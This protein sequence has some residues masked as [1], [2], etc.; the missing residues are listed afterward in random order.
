MTGAGWN[1]KTG[2][3]NTSINYQEAITHFFSK[4][5]IMKN[6]YKLLLFKSILEINKTEN[7]ILY[8]IVIKFAEL[9]FLYKKEYPIDITIYNG[10]SEKSTLDI[11]VEEIYYS[12]IY[13]YEKISD[14]NKFLYV[15]EAK[16]VLKRN[17]IGAFYTSLKKIPYSFDLSFEYIKLNIN[18]KTFLD[19]NK[20]KLEEIIE[21]RMIEFFKVSE[22]DEE[23]LEK[24]LKT[25][26]F[27]IGED[28]Y[29]KIND[30]ITNLKY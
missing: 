18:F 6:L 22:K 29:I 1:L 17:V 28:F 12:K 16:Q 11:K 23:K 27:S 24:L 4:R 14:E 9:Y 20:E 2:E 15:N 21:L 8:D 26:G 10:N 25:K 19:R 3:I 5:N 13:E 30:L 7:N